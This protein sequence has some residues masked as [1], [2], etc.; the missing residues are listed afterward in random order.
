MVLTPTGDSLPLAM[1]Y[2]N[3]FLTG[4]A[5]TPRVRMAL[6]TVVEEVFM[7]I[8]HHSHAT[9]A[10]FDLFKDGELIILRFTDDGIPYNPLLRDA[11]DITLPASQRDIGGLGVFMIRRM[12]DRQEYAYRDNRNVLTLIKR[13]T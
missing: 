1:D 2:L 10:Q 6:E 5:C 8:A 13:E 3:T 4:T 9:F 11:P 7:N 12:T